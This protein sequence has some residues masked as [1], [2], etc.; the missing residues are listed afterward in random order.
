MDKRSVAKTTG[1]DSPACGG[2]ATRSVFRFLLMNAWD[3]HSVRISTGQ[4]F[5]VL[6]YKQSP[7]L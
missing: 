4:N 2:G 6:I 7:Y 5:L 3:L 1:V